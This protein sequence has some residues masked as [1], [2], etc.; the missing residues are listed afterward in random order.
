MSVAAPGLDDGVLT[1]LS[2]R[3]LIRELARLEEERWLSEVDG[4]RTRRLEEA[5]V[6]E[7]RRRG[8][9]PAEDTAA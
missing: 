8:R 9:Q 7:L 4:D 2:I 6:V 1:G 5:I 3:E